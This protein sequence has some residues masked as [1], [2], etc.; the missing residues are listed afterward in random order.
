MRAPWVYR[1]RLI[2]GESLD[3]R[4]APSHPF[5]TDPSS[6][7]A[8]PDLKAVAIERKVRELCAFGF[9]SS[10]HLVLA[11]GRAIDREITSAASA[12][13]L[14]SDGALFKGNRVQTIGL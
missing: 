7:L 3:R 5:R 9:K 13:Q 6:A 4:R 8:A 1:K 10:A 11:I 2:G 12:Q 14:A